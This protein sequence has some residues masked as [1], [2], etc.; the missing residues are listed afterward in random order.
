MLISARELHTHLHDPAWVIF[1]CRHDLVDHSR[2]ARVYAERHIPGARFAAIETDLSGRKTGVNGRHPLPEPAAFAEFLARSGVTPDSTIVAYDDSGGAYAI[3][4]WWLARWIGHACVV[5]LDGGLPAWLTQKFPTDCAVSP[6]AAEAAAYPISPSGMPVVQ[7]D[8]VLE[9]LSTQ[10]FVL[11]DARA[12][13]RFRGETEPMDS[14]VGHIPGARNRFHKTNL[15]ADLTFRPPEELRAEFLALLAGR[16][17]SELV[18]YCGSGVTA[19][20]NLFA[21]ELA[22]LMGSQLYAG[23]WSE[24]A[25]DPQR[26]VATGA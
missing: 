12:G 10:R 23:S 18:H 11:L 13:E 3:R 4:L 19:G 15:N 9:S 1:D 5:V 7:A 16:P 25:S 21:M 22:G 17:P 2:G 6:P 24:W 8:E 14:V 20:V 26:P